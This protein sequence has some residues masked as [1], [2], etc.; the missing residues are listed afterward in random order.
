MNDEIVELHY[1]KISDAYIQIKP[2]IP[3]ICRVSKHI[4]KIERL[5]ESIFKKRK[6]NGI[7]NRKREAVGE[8]A[9]ASPIRK[10]GKIQN[11][12]CRLTVSNTLNNTIT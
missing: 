12:P 2:R 11:S 10:Q 8:Q 9:V 3:I 7:V 5:K 6:E 4:D 1:K